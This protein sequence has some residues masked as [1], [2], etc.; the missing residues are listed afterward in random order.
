MR[1]NGLIG[2]QIF[3]SLK[4]KRKDCSREVHS[5]VVCTVCLPV[6]IPDLYFLELNSDF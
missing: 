4:G 1:I 6:H 5:T 3:C 2:V